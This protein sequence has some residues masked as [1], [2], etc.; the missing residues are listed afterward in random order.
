M[1]RN[2]FKFHHHFLPFKEVLYIT[3][4]LCI[5]KHAELTIILI[6]PGAITNIPTARSAEARE[7][8]NRASGRLR[9]FLSFRMMTRVVRFPEIVMRIRHHIKITARTN[10]GSM[11][12][13][14]QLLSSIHGYPRTLIISY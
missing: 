5:Y 6:T 9:S 4:A 8:R 3:Y 1:Y 2:P 12:T 11:T 10:P 7:R 14:V 13:S